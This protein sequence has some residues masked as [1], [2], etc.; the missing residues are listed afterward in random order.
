MKTRCWKRRHYFY[1]IVLPL[2][3]CCAV[4]GLSSCEKKAKVAII[5]KWQVSGGNDTC[6]FRKDGVF[7]NIHEKTIGPPE[8]AHVFKQETAGT[9]D[10]EDASH[11]HVLLDQGG[12]FIQFRVHIHGDRMNGTMTVGDSPQHTKQYEINLK[13]LK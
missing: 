4:L 11:L 6:E 12:I 3:V 7:V 1:L 13:R 9:W 2:L 8:N 5:G 10:F